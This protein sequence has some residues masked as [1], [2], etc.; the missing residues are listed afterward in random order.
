MQNITSLRP[1]TLPYFV[2]KMLVNF[3]IFFYRYH[4]YDLARSAYSQ[5]ESFHSEFCE[6][7]LTSFCA[8]LL[9]NKQSENI[10][11]L[12]KV[13]IILCYLN[14]RVIKLNY[15]KCISLVKS[16]K[17]RLNAQQI[18]N[19]SISDSELI[20]TVLHIRSI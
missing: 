20:F 7:R 2:K 11:F 15:S 12:A 8:I 1:Y 16:K 17:T 18:N 4:L 3:T 14:C 10:T 5:L 6:N 19:F 13:I 9:T